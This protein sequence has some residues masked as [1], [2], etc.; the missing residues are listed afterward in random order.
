[1]FIKPKPAKEGEE[2]KAR[3][4]LDCIPRN[5]VIEKDKIPLPKIKDLL[6]WAAKKNFLSL[7][8][9]EDGF[10]N[11]RIHKDYVKFSAF[12]CLRGTFVSKVMQQGD[13]NAP[14]TM[15]RVMNHLLKDQ[16]GEDLF[17]Y[18]DDIIIGSSTYEEHKKAIRKM[19]Q[20]LRENKFFLNK[21]KCSI[22]A[23]KTKVLGFILSKAG[24]EADPKKIKG[25]KEMEMPNTRK[26]LQRF[27]G[28]GQYLSDLIPHYGTIV[29]PLYDLTSN[30]TKYKIREIHETAFN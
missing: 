20:T 28:M 15:M 19:M 1:M 27:L 8:D 21:D 25:I 5:D 23:P 4:L 2:P 11:I 30:K 9:L 22:M 26:R 12:T 24:I 29:V 14:R 6:S 7:F 13:C 16:L 3:F 10:H 17:I 18:L